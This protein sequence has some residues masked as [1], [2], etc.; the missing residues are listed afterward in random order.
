MT[1]SMES[2][3]QFGSG[4]LLYTRIAD[5]ICE[6]IKDN[7]I[8]IGEKIPSERTLS[9]IMGVSRNSVREAIRELEGKGIL[10]VE[11]GRGS[12]LTGEVTDRAMLIKIKKQSFFELFEVKTVLER[13]VIRELIYELK[14]DKLNELEE[15]AQKMVKLSRAGIFPQKLDDIFHGKLLDSY[16]NKAM[17]EIVRKLMLT[18]AEYNASYFNTGFGIVNEKNQSVLDTIP[19]HLEMIRCMK[20]RDLESTME[21]YNEIVKID[22][23]IYSLVQE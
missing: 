18:F 9:V 23:S 13:H 5:K 10:H 19:L 20:R 3:I 21:A 15:L 8:K 7:E 12:F 2:G 14:D 17:G 11:A 1:G 6:Y 4:Q 16:W 22:I